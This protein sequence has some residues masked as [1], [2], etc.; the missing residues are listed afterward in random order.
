[1]HAN[2]NTEDPDN[3]SRNESNY[4][5]TPLINTTSKSQKGNKNNVCLGADTQHTFL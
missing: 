3:S 2:F 4:N 5:L 1:M